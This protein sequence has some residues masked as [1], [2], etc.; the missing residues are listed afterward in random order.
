MNLERKAPERRKQPERSRSR[1]RSRKRNRRKDPKS[2]WRDASDKKNQETKTIRHR[3]MPASQNNKKCTSLYRFVAR[4]TEGV[5]G[6]QSKDEIKI[7]LPGRRPPRSYW[8]R[9]S[10]RRIRLWDSTCP[11]LRPLEPEGRVACAVCR[12]VLT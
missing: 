8:Q 11:A 4:I 7:G 3:S 1:S 6:V 5:K 2:I 10:W 9:S 12:Q